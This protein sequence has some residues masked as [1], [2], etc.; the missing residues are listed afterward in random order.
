MDSK[1]I[2]KILLKT[3]NYKNKNKFLDDL[4]MK[5]ILIEDIKDYILKLTVGEETMVYCDKLMYAV[6]NKSDNYDYP[7]LEFYSLEYDGTRISDI[8]YDEEDR[9]FK[10]YLS[11]DYWNFDY[12]F[13]ENTFNIFV[14]EILPII[15]NC[16]I[17][18]NKLLEEIN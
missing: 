2:E 17:Q 3:M 8:Y 9:I 10:L 1:R 14:N 12:S 15:Q 6:L 7:E 4:K 11:I 5:N 13:D 18:C 16:L